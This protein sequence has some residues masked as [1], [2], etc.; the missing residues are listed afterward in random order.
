MSYELVLL[1]RRGY[2]FVPN[3]SVVNRIVSWLLVSRDIAS[4]FRDL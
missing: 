3:A 4:A 2:N 1:V